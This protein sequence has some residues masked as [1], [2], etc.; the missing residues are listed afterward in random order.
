VVNYR[1]E[2]ET[3][4]LRQFTKAFDLLSK[5]L[6][7]KIMDALDETD[8]M[9]MVTPL[10]VGESRATASQRIMVHPPVILVYRVNLRLQIVTIVDPNIL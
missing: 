9:L 3:E 8:R 2:W 10:E 6:Q 7:V 5:P 1:I 4:V